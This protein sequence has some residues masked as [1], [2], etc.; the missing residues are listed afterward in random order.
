MKTKLSAGNAMSGLFTVCA[1]AA[2]I[3]T[4]VPER[5]AQ[6]A[7]APKPTAAAAV[8]K[9]VDVQ[10]ADVIAAQGNAAVR[11]IQVDARPLPPDLEMI[12]VEGRE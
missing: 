1:I 9:V 2:A 11:Q 8:P 6:D 5:V 12:A 3:L 10:L 4:L 7:Q